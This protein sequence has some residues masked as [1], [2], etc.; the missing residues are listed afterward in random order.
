[1]TRGSSAYCL[2]V[3]RTRLHSCSSEQCARRQRC[4]RGWTWDNAEGTLISTWT[5][6]RVSALQLPP[7]AAPN[8]LR[9]CTGL[10]RWIHT[11]YKP[12][13]AWHTELC[14]Y[15]W[16]TL[17]SCTTSGLELEQLNP[18]GSPRPSMG[19]RTTE[20]RVATGVYLLGAVHL[21][22]QLM[23]AVPSPVAAWTNR[24]TT[25]RAHIGSSL[26]VAYYIYI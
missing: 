23:P 19:D 22:Y 8:L 7:E 4:S 10:A 21:G 5:T 11:A 20:Q 9:M 15:K 1:M 24:S 14:C 2:F 16:R 18:A 17:M 12:W 6:S 3:S 13:E 26:W 25:V